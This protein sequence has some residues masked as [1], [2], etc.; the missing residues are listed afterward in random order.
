MEQ[1]TPDHF[2]QPPA[3]PKALKLH[4]HPRWG[5]VL[6][7]CVTVVAL[8]YLNR[9]KAPIDWSDMLSLLGVRYYHDRFT[10]T[11]CLA[12]VLLG[13]LAILRILRRS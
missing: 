10:Q 7:P 8:G 1:P 3:P 11:T 5:W 4:R 2:D 6:V 13:I 12:L 9:M